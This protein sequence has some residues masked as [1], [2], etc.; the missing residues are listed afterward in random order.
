MINALIS[1][2]TG[3]DGS[4]LAEQLLD[5]G[6]KVTGIVR[7][8][9]TNNLR[10]IEHLIGREGF[11]LVYGDVTDAGFIHSLVQGNA[12]GEVYNLAAQ[13]FVGTSF[14][15]PSHTTHVILDGCLNFLEAIRGM[16]P[17]RRPRFYQASTSE[18][19]GSMYSIE[20]DYDMYTVVEHFD[21][22]VVTPDE[23]LYC[24]DRRHKSKDERQKHIE[25]C[26]AL[27][28]WSPTNVWQNENTPFLPSSPYAVAK[29][30]AHNL[31][32]IY[33]DSYGLFACSGILFNH[34]SPRRGDEFVTRKITKYLGKLCR[35]GLAKAGHL[36]L[37]NI[38]ASR[39]W[40][41]ARDYVRGQVLMLRHDTPDDYV[42]AT[43]ETH[44]VREFLDT[45]FGLIGLAGL[46]WAPCVK[47]SQAEMRPSEV[48]YLR[49]NA[50]KAKHVLKWEP[51]VTF[52]QLVA[53]M[54]D[55]DS[56]EEMP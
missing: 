10:R 43:G 17:E 20:Q 56:Y 13:S 39:D 24:D 4:Y 54:V 19:F 14:A 51:A 55:S 53:E 3:Q 49:G 2:V 52:K 47:I 45:A 26:K 34:E 12:F 30:A 38:E 18:M 44:T 40:G 7:R 11:S 9:S 5:E 6:S 8:S 23:K 41:H 31:V 32:K 33:R 22:K 50:S 15:E 28:T 27:A 36:N 48:P 1:G 42:L 46:D 16:S 29:L 25:K 21:F 35:E 37:G